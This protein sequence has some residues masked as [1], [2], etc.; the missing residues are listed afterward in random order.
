MAQYLIAI[1]HPGDFDPSLATA[2]TVRDIDVLN[3]EMEAAGVRMF[4]GGLAGAGN[5]KS[6][7]AQPD[8]KVL[9]TDGP[10]LPT[11]EHVG[12]FWILKAA[13]LDEAAGRR[14]RYSRSSD[15]AKKWA[16]VDFRSLERLPDNRTM[17][18]GC[19]S[20]ET[21]THRNPGRNG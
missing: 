5:A 21:K 16:A 6:L 8:S 11:K 10:Y 7:R 14:S 9:V 3:G 17:N 18:C 20:E 1:H 13:N 12:G 2:S 19:A 15:E 4:A